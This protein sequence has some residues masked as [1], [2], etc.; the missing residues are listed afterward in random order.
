MLR[1]E[2]VLDHAQV[3][4]SMPHAYVGRLQLPRVIGSQTKL[5]GGWSVLLL[6]LDVLVGRKN[7]TLA[8]RGH[9]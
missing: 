3:L 7:L 8:S 5:L 9:T 1:G 6:S 4:Y 2:D